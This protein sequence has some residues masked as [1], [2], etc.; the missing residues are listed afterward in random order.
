M[1]DNVQTKK[2]D[3][4][5][6]KKIKLITPNCYKNISKYF[7]SLFEQTPNN[8]LEKEI[9]KYL[10]S[11]SLTNINYYFESIT[12]IFACEQD[13]YIAKKLNNKCLYA[14]FT[15][16][17]KLMS[18]I[19]YKRTIQEIYKIIEDLKNYQFKYKEIINDKRFNHQLESLDNYVNT[20][21][22]EIINDNILYVYNAL[23]GIEFDKIYIPYENVPENTFVVNVGYNLKDY[24]YL[25][26]HIENITHPFLTLEDVKNITL[27]TKYE[28]IETDKSGLCLKSN[29][30][31]NNE[32]L[33]VFNGYKIQ[34]DDK[35]N[36]I[37]IGICYNNSKS[38]EKCL[39]SISKNK[40]TIN[41]LNVLINGGVI[42]HFNTRTNLLYINEIFSKNKEYIKDLDKLKTIYKIKTISI[43]ELTKKIIS[44][45]NEDYKKT[46]YNIQKVF[47]D[48]YLSLYIQGLKY[49][50]E[51]GTVSFE[52]YYE[53]IKPYF[54][55]DL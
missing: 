13:K 32:E 47:D 31:I 9:D 33:S 23:Y 49:I 44:C 25:Y 4:E 6:L 16:Y 43:E 11:F 3:I 5:E 54:L 35:I 55:F 52:K 51:N 15:K 53:F 27:P 30:K 37:N 7:V 14:I 1:N 22:K 46:I 8:V 38:N 26:H 12:Y 28:I 36:E 18:Q 40:Y 50:Q 39:Y 17:P 48:K 19:L 41:D 2:V 29:L 45:Y 21:Y 10:N 20:Y 34:N 42:E 24:N